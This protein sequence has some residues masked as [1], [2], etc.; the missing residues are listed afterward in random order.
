[1]AKKKKLQSQDPKEDD[2]YTADDLQ[3]ALH[4][5]EIEE[6][7]DKVKSELSVKHLLVLIPITFVIWHQKSK[8]ETVAVAMSKQICH[9]FGIDTTDIKVKCKKPYTNKIMALYASCKCQV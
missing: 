6:F 3:N 9:H 1:M 7:S 4:Q 5:N 2:D 8:L